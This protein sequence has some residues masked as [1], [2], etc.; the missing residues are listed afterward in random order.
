M[1]QRSKL[2]QTTA[3]L[4]RLSA[5]SLQK[6]QEQRYFRY[7]V[8][9]PPSI[10]NRFENLIQ[11]YYHAQNL[12]RAEYTF[13]S[14]LQFDEGMN[15]VS[16]I[17]A[18]G[19][20][21]YSFG[22]EESTANK[23]HI[24]PIKERFQLDLSNPNHS[25]V[26]FRFFYQ[27]LR[28]SLARQGF[29]TRGRTAFERKT[30]LLKEVS[31]F[32]TNDLFRRIQEYIH[33]F[34]AFNFGLRKFGDQFFLQ[35]S[36]RTLLEFERDIYS[37]QS[38]GVFSA[39]EFTELFESVALPVG[40]AAKLYSISGKTVID[41]IEERPFNGASFSRFAEKMYPQLRFSKY[42]A[43]LILVLPYGNATVPWYFSTEL[44]KPSLRFSDIA[45]WDHDFYFKILSE[46]KIHSA[47]R[48]ELI[49][50]Y[51]RRIKFDFFDLKL[52]MS[53]QFSYEGPLERLQP[54]Q[55][56][57][58]TDSPSF[59][60]P[61]PWIS[62]RDKRSNR[63][64]H[65]NRDV[66]GHLGATVDLL[67]REELGCV[68][69]P[70]DIKVKI[71]SDEALY[72]DTYNLT[73]AMIR[74]T[75]G[76]RGFSEIFESEL[77][78]D[79]ITTV[80]DLSAQTDIYSDVSPENYDCVLV[81]GPRRIAGSREK[82]RRIYTFAETEILNRGVPVQF[83]A[84]EP[85]QNKIYDK[86]LQ[87]K[88]NNPYALFGIGLNILGKIG[89]KVMVLSPNTTDH[90]TPDSAVIGYNIVRIFEPI[91][92]DISQERS[93]RELIRSSTPL[94][95]PLVMLT[96]DGAEIVV[97]DVYQIPDEVSLFREGRAERMINSLSG[98]FHSFIIHKD[99]RFYSDELSDIKKLQQPDQ[100]IVPVSIVSGLSPRLFSSISA[101]NYIPPM[102]TVTMLS[103]KDFLMV[104][105]LI[106]TRYEP[107]RRG[108]PNTILITIHD[109]ALGKELP[110]VEKMR[111]LFQIWSLTRVHMGSQLP[112]R[113]PMSI[114]YSDLM[115]TFL[116]KAGD[117]QPRYFRR[118]GRKRNR[119]GYI[120]RIFL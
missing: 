46:M 116:R 56:D 16:P 82:S 5:E 61:S 6:I 17:E 96:K 2:V 91:R 120:P 44:T 20:F 99:G 9:I 78:Y 32:S 71:I 95:A 88:S 85:T 103:S 62:F 110:S 114:H 60:L 21:L 76:Y 66:T 45:G 69:Y 38:A 27:S 11:A 70:K 57:K 18:D 72:G 37:L 81:F 33:L 15:I 14:L 90:F 79:G 19:E 65:V 98:D 58:K 36:P 105:P 34:P 55:F 28:R 3:E 26:F 39:N 13:S 59:I 106:T 35:I 10:R 54:T 43:N 51:I 111:I 94:T 89:A 75:R 4:V 93:P 68:H 97:Q 119:L 100:L 101:W 49:E 41:P 8:K 109:E 47:R 117:P 73:E 52:E 22:K 112:T 24:E 104:T 23:I 50:D 12:F 7:R 74:G 1:Y 53:G 48:K 107:R 83:I 113:K 64:V 102:G 115:A 31:H 80:E 87:T 42:D 63:I 108:W 25:R 29:D 92:K 40:R 77:I 67:R 84:D 86:S 30:D 118:F